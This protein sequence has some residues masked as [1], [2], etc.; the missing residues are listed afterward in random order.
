MIKD[1]KK[2]MKRAINGEELVIGFLGGSIT[3]GSLATSDKKTYAYLVYDW[4]CRSFPKAE[5]HYVNAGIGGTTS[6][7]GVARA[8][9]DFL[10]YRPDFAVVDFSV[11]DEPNEFFMETYEGLIRKLLR[12]KSA[13]AILALCNA[14]YKDLKTAE[15]YH[16]RV[17]SY[18]DIPYISIRNRLQELEKDESYQSSQLSPDGL[19]PNDTG[20]MKVAEDIIAKLETIKAEVMAETSEE[21]S[22]ETLHAKEI[23]TPENRVTGSPYC[24][25]MY[26]QATLW[27]IT[28]ADP[29]LHGF[30]AD[31]REKMGHLDF[32]KNGW[33]GRNDKDEIVF[34]LEC[35][36]IAIQ[37]K[38][39]VKHPAKKA[40]AILDGDC[41][42]K[43]LLDG[44]FEETWGDCLF[45]TEI[46]HDDIKKDHELKIVVEDQVSPAEPFYLL[47]II[48]A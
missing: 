42:N 21:T 40:Y 44:N 24:S 25:D 15:D 17:L 28:N 32:F 43:I 10:M 2:L 4:W 31:Y 33:I 37:Y 3:Q 7:F 38:K 6:Y 26:E 8:D 29:A 23:S 39:D 34:S 46:L 48:T 20:H 30:M 1:I 19:H 27:N 45:L 12:S 11:N 35:R 47:S 41:K 18:Y 36:S 13:P 14:Y 5:F 9:K 22:E 16:A